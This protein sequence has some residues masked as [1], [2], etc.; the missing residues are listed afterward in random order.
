MWPYG[1]RRVMG[2]RVFSQ[3]NTSTAKRHSRQRV[4][5][6]G[7]LLRHVAHTPGRVVYVSRSVPFLIHCGSASIRTATSPH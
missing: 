7:V 3:P 1:R 6:S 4:V 5:A 2:R